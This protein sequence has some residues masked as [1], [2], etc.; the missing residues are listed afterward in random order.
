MLLSYFP[1]SV[2][3]LL[4]RR[5]TLDC[6]R[7]CM[8]DIGLSETISKGEIQSSEVENKATIFGGEN[9]E[10]H[11]LDLRFIEV[12]RLVYRTQEQ[13]FQT[14]IHDDRALPQLGTDTSD[15][16]H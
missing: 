10:Y 13:L 16:A 12:H 4:K 3:L 7:L 6:Y 11:C 9:D 1:Y 14:F 15:P 8:Q 2:T 5:F